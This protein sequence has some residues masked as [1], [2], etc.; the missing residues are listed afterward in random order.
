MASSP[1]GNRPSLPR[2]LRELK[3]LTQA[4]LAAML[5]VQKPFVSQCENGLKRPGLEVA[6]RWEQAIGCP[7]SYWLTVRVAKEAA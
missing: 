3:K 1:D 5:G 2:E 7:V 4:E 6:Q